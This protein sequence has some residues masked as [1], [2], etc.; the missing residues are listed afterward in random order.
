MGIVSL[1]N[2]CSIALIGNESLSA[3]LRCLTSIELFENAKYYA[4]HPLIESQHKNV[5][6][7]SLKNAFAMCV[8]DA[9]LTFFENSNEIAAV[10]E[11]AKETAKTF[12][13]LIH[14]VH[15]C[16]VHSNAVYHSV[17][18]PTHQ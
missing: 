9:A 14:G 11:E 18:L 13:I 3:H 5:A 6:F 12:H 7:T 2:A 10:L 8:S 15:V 1:I 17:I 16:L 4:N